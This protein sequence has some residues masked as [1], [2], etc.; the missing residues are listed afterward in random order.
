MVVLDVF[1]VLLFHLRKTTTRKAVMSGPG[2][3]PREAHAHRTT[4]H[5]QVAALGEDPAVEEVHGWQARQAIHPI[6]F[7]L[8]LHRKT[9]THYEE[10]LSRGMYLVRQGET[11]YLFFEFRNKILLNKGPFVLILT[12]RP[13][14]ILN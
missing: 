2:C 1:L 4:W 13:L 8:P 11:F 3:S 5:R 12:L 6:L 9:G 7:S 10:T 14:L